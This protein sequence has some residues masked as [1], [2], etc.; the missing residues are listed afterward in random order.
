VAGKSL[1]AGAHLAAVFSEREAPLDPAQAR[2]LLDT[3]LRLFELRALVFED[4][5][6]PDSPPKSTPDGVLGSGTP[7]SPLEGP[8]VYNMGPSNMGPSVHRDTP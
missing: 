7:G 5:G 2:Q 8:T 4:E 6:C 3:L 1:Q